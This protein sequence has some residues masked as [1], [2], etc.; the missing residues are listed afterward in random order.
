MFTDVVF[1]IAVPAVLVTK[2][3]TLL[4]PRA[5]PNETGEYAF[6][7]WPASRLTVVVS[8]ATV[9][10]AVLRTTLYTMPVSRTARLLTYVST[11]K[12]PMVCIFGPETRVHADVPKSQTGQSDART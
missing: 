7:D 11:I 1:E 10:P 2:I 12:G 5:R 6:P 4:L 3:E 8:Y 9:C